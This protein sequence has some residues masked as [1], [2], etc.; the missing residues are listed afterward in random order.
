M[1]LVAGVKRNQ[2]AR[3]VNR[4]ASYVFPKV[5]LGF[6]RIWVILAV[7]EKERGGRSVAD[8]GLTARTVR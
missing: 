3:I 6:E 1:P 5:L 2:P 7:I 8:V 4:G